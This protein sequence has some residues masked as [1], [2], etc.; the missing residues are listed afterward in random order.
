MDET[1][2]ALRDRLLNAYAPYLG[3]VLAARGWPADSAP[4]REGEAWL[5]NAL[6]EL[7]DL[8][9]P[10][11][12]RT[13]L[14]VFQEAFAAPND[15]LAAQGVPAPR[16]DPVVVAAMPGD[17]YDLAPASSAALGEDV[18][19]SHLE[20]GA[21]KAAAVTRPTLAVLA[22][23]L[24]DRD[25]IERVAV[26]RGYRVQ[27]IQGPDRVR[28]HALVL[29]DL[30]DAAADATIAAAAGEGIRVIG[31]GPHVDEFALI[32]ARSLGATA[33]MARSQFFRDLAELLPSFV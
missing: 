2:R 26:A 11:Q 17:T 3:G 6:D 30:T 8:P 7:L 33:A 23:N 16:R 28:G 18:W 20:W 29:V 4:I 31:F 13:P 15:A 32:R 10:E 21:A 14:E 1:S 25:R 24:L 27:P 22:A 12:R 19:R 5:R 9:Y